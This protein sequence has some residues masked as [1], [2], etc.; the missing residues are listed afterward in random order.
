MNNNNNNQDIPNGI[1]DFR[2]F[3]AGRMGRRILT[4]RMGGGSY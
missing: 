2:G 1:I 3:R 4:R